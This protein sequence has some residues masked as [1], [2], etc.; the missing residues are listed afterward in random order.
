MSARWNSRTADARRHALAVPTCEE[1]TQRDSDVRAE[2]EPVGQDRRGQAVRLEALRDASTAGEHQPG[3]RPQ[4]VHG[5]PTPPGVTE[6][7][8]E[9]GRT[10][11]IHAVAVR[12]ELDVVAERGRDLRGI[13]HTADPGQHRDE[14]QRIALLLAQLH[15]GGQLRCDLPRPQ[16]MFHWLPEPEVGGERERGQQFGQGHS[17]IGLGLLHRRSLQATRAAPWSPRSPAAARPDWTKYG[18]RVR[19]VCAVRGTCGGWGGSGWNSRT[20]DVGSSRPPVVLW[21]GG[22]SAPVRT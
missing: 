5:R 15:V 11:Q 7:E 17:G 1:L 12:T 3:G 8:P 13:G 2:P 22:H 14:E 20:G 6:K 16:H 9:R 10:G 19:P 4:A 18:H 21:V